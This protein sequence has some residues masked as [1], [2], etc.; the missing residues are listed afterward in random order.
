MVSNLS[1]NQIRNYSLSEIIAWKRSWRQR[2]RR[3]A[4]NRGERR[5]RGWRWA[6]KLGSLVRHTSTPTVTGVGIGSFPIWDGQSVGRTAGLVIRVVLVFELLVRAWIVGFKVGDLSCISI[7][8]A[9]ACVDPDLYPIAAFGR[10]VLLGF[11]MYHHHHT[12]WRTIITTFS[13]II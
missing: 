9:R 8:T 13:Y 1:G 3:C 10:T 6:P 12:F 11:L 2:R 5:R 7:W 4:G